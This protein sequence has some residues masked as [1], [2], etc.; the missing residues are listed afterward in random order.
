MSFLKYYW[1]LLKVLPK[2]IIFLVWVSIFLILKKEH[3][4][5]GDIFYIATLILITPLLQML[6]MLRLQIW[7]QGKTKKLDCQNK[8]KKAANSQE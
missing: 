3:T 2:N 5:L 8:E 1:V 7:K 6:Y 4:L